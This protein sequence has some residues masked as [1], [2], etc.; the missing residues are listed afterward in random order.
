MKLEEYLHELE[1][2]DSRTLRDEYGIRDNY[3][4]ALATDFISVIEY[5]KNSNKWAF[6]KRRNSGSLEDRKSPNSRALMEKL[7]EREKILMESECL[8]EASSSPSDAETESG[9]SIPFDYLLASS[10]A[11]IWD[12]PSFPDIFKQMDK[13]KLKGYFEYRKKIGLHTYPCGFSFHPNSPPEDSV[14]S[15]IDFS[16]EF[17][18]ANKI[19][20][21]YPNSIGKMRKDILDLSKIVVYDPMN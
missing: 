6:G 13:T 1:N 2:N 8:A 15:I 9:I 5:F 17:V 10:I 16:R 7:D 4:I 20:A 18:I 11:N 12:Y 14:K 21:V 19:P 3:E